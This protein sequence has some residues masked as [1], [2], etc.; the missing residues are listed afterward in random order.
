MKYICPAE[1]RPHGFAGIALR[2]VTVQVLPETEQ[3]LA[4]RIYKRLVPMARALSGRKEMHYVRKFRHR[5][6]NVIRK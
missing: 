5:P 6:C 1:N 4:G 3:T 2:Q